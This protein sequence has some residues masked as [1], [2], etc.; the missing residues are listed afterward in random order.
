VAKEK[1]AQTQ[2]E[3]DGN[4][5][6]LVWGLPRPTEPLSL[7]PGITLRPLTNPLSIFDLAAAGAVGFRSWAILEPAARGCSCE[8]ESAKD[9]ATL[10]GYDTLNRAWLASSLLVLRGYTQQM[11]VACSTYSWNLIA[12]H[13]K[14]STEQLQ[15]F[16]GDLLDFHLKLQRNHNAKKG[17]VT[18]TD[19]SWVN[20]HFPTF[21]KLASESE[22]FRFALEAAVDW[23]YAKDAR[24]AVS[25]LWSGI[26]ALFG[27]KSE[28]VYRI[29]LYC[30]CLQA[31]RGDGRIKKFHQVKE[32]YDLRSKAVHGATLSDEEMA[33][34]LNDS[35][36]LLSG[37]LLSTISRGRIP[38]SDDLDH[39][40]FGE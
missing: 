36:E 35:F 32:L 24:A 18:P 40:V 20:G 15:T 29:S 39:A 21:N 1:T 4:W 8:I 9:A 26:E 3:H 22:S 14:I 16:R 12:G 37:L 19:A 7:A 25:R 6:V 13:Q 17:S 31:K 10:P 5:Y 38:T 34:A 11:C 27:I 2:E 23:R 33:S 30:A 28:L